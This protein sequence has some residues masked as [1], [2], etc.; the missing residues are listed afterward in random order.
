MVKH[1]QNLTKAVGEKLVWGKRMLRQGPF[2]GIVHYTEY[3][4]YKNL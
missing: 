3:G 1:S 2:S 4:S